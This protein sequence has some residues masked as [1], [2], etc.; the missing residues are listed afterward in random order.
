MV[1]VTRSIPAS[2][3]KPCTNGFTLF[4]I[5]VKEALAAGTLSYTPIPKMGSNILYS[6]QVFDDVRAGAQRPRRG[7]RRLHGAVGRAQ[8]RAD[9]GRRGRCR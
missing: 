1:A 2:E 8:P 3:A 7:R 9:P 4:L 5:D 6:S